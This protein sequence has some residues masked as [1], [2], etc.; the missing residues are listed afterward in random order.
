MPR[1]PGDI[2]STVVINSITG[3]ELFIFGDTI[4][5]KTNDQLASSGTTSHGEVYQPLVTKAGD[6]IGFSESACKVGKLRGNLIVGM[7]GDA[8]FGFSILENLFDLCQGI[9]KSAEIETRVKTICQSLSPSQRSENTGAEFLF[10]LSGEKLE[11]SH[12]VI[13]VDNNGLLNSNFSFVEVT[14][15]LCHQRI[16]GVGKDY[17]N[18]HI[19]RSICDA[20]AHDP[21]LISVATQML[22]ME[23]SKVLR[24]KTHN[25]AAFVGGAFL[26]L[27]VN[28]SGVLVPRDTLQ[29]FADQNDTITYLTKTAYESGLFIITDFI[30]KK[31]NVVRTIEE[32]IL[33]RKG[34]PRTQGD[35]TEII[36][37]KGAFSAPVSFLSAFENSESEPR[38]SIIENAGEN[39]LISNGP[40]KGL[41][42]FEKN[43]P[44]K[45]TLSDG[46]EREFQIP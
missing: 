26:G 36:N 41:V 44:L 1:A 38:V 37:K 30:R 5:T 39:A 8:D 24:S 6:V 13:R 9:K 4:V 17:L 19:P 3:K 18:G 25:Q 21:S 42:W 46:V 29:I 22:C 27:M 14:P 7:A 11:M 15:Q 45:I 23:Y 43:S 20:C 33:F 34:I 2:I 10:A 12:C 40:S 32:E 16:I 35:I 28:H 31:V